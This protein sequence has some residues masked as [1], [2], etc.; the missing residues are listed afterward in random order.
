MAL[1]PLRGFIHR[2]RQT[3]GL[4]RGLLT[5]APSG[6][7]TW[8][9]LVLQRY[10]FPKTQCSR[11]LGPD[12]AADCSHGWSIARAQPRDAEPVDIRTISRFRPGGAEE[13]VSRQTPRDLTSPA[14]R[15]PF[16]AEL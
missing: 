2:D 12:G 9:Y 10:V 7:L 5:D 1:S 6:L 14:F 15:C 4:R 3:R 13:C 8:Y 11:F 16:G